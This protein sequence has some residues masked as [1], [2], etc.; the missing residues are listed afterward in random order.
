MKTPEDFADRFVE[1]NTWR[2]DFQIL[3]EAMAETYRA[4]LEAAA[5]ANCNHCQNHGPPTG[6][7]DLHP[8][9]DSLCTSRHIRD[10]PLPE[11]LQE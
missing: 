9:C 7:H 2:E 10:L 4:G 1:L 3:R 11:E 8:E 6:L 5:M